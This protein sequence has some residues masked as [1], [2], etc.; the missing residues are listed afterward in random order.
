MIIQDSK[1]VLKNIISEVIE[2]DT[3]ED[4]ANFIEELGIDSM[5]IIEILVRVEKKFKITITED[6]IPR[7]TDLNTM[8]SAVQELIEN[9]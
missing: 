3:F 6:Y 9:K 4:D 8:H 7:F 1:E 5:M 2:E